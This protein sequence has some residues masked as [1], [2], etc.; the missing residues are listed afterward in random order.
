MVGKRTVDLAPT[1]FNY[2]LV[3]ARHA[4][5]VVDYQ[6]LVTEAQGYETDAREAQEL[7][8]WH[9]HQIREA[10]EPDVQRPTYIINIRGSGYRLVVD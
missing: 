10:I 7:A 1:A 9:V 4:S 8:K 5:S 3:L 6:T 2:L